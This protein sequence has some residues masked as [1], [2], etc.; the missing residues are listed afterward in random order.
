MLEMGDPSFLRLEEAL[1]Y[2]PFSRLP[3]PSPHLDSFVPGQGG[4]IH[5]VIKVWMKEL[6]VSGSVPSS[7]SLLLSTC[8][9]RVYIQ[10]PKGVL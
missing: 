6:S 8:L 2:A 7:T 10:A 9:R 5:L 1:S 3:F 4:M